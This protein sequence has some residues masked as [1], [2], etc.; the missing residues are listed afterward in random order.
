MDRKEKEVLIEARIVQVVLKNEFRMGI[1]WDAIVKS[2]H[3]LEFKSQLGGVGTTNNGSLAIGTLSNDNYQ[4]VIQAIGNVNKSHI[5][6]NPRVAVLN[7]QEAKIL[8]GTTQPYVT[9][10]TTTPSSGPV[11][12]SEDVKFIDVG[13]KL[14]VTPT[15]HPD[16]YVT[17]KIRPEVS[18]APTSITTSDNNTIPIVD[19]SEVETTVQVKDGVTIIIG[20]LI[21]TEKSN[22]V[23]KVPLLGN[24]PFL[25][26]AFRNTDRNTEQTEIIIFLTPRIISGDLK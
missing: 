5:L 11:T 3:G 13:V 6:S 18:S 15:I 21:K 17:M 10:Q 9:T 16:G 19:T 12:V 4:A 20:G 24:I 7:N 2:T 1:N 25:G 22:Q 8:I 23:S 14:A 26:A